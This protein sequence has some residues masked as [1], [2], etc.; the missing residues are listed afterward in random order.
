M[1]L[2][3]LLT[4]ARPYNFCSDHGDGLMEEPVAHGLQKKEEVGRSKLISVSIPIVPS[5]FTQLQ[6]L[7][8]VSHR[9]YKRLPAVQSAKSISHSDSV[10]KLLLNVDV[11]FYRPYPK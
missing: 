9:N 10:T 2:P 1:L 4:S 7:Q 8:H 6:R 5:P 11:S 3:L